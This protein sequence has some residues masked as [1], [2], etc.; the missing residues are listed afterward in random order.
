MRRFLA[1]TSLCACVVLG[2]SALLW[3]SATETYKGMCDG[4]AGTAI[5]PDLFVVAND[6]GQT[7]RVY[8]RGTP[9][10]LKE[11]DTDLNQF[12]GTDQ[13]N[14]HEADIEAAA[15]VNNRIYWITSHG[16]DSD[17]VERE[18]RRR[19]FATEI[20]VASGKVTI[21]PVQRP[22]IKLLDDL[23]GAESLRKYKSLLQN[24]A[25]IA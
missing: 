13:S 20:K 16:R 7:L 23:F 11:F 15:R 18:T 8:R 5:T 2:T 10:P 14:D 6:D 25:K 1:S 22:Y 9:E 3:A 4:S 17:G 19:F 12:L 21:E 24:G